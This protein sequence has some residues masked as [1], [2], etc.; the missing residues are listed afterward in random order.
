[1]YVSTAS[2]HLLEFITRFEGE[3]APGRF[4]Q[5]EAEVTTEPGS[6]LPISIRVTVDVTSATMGSPDLDEGISEPEWFDFSAYPQATFTSDHIRPTAGAGY[7]ADGELR[8]KGV[9]RKLKVSF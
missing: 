7:L 5:F 4:S 1:M 8:L 9:R 3:K 6:A 2:E